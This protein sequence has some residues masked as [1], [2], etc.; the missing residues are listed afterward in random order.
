VVVVDTFPIFSHHPDLPQYP[1]GVHLLPKLVEMG[2][3]SPL[4]PPPP[5]PR[6]VVVVIIPETLLPILVLV[7]FPP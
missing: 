1:I 5:L 7:I 2:T 6:A 4:H 3:L